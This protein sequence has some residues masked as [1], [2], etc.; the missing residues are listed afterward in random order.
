V[1]AS[2]NDG[3]NHFGNQPYSCTERNHE[4]Y[5]SPA[6]SFQAGRAL[7]KAAGLAPSSRLLGVFPAPAFSTTPSRLRVRDGVAATPAARFHTVPAR[8][9]DNDGK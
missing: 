5:L 4:L 7:R 3:V 2:W 8:W 9:N 6:M 1:A